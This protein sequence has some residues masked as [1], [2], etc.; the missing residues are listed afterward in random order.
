MASET[1]DAIPNAKLVILE[2]AGHFSWLEA[3]AAF[4][5]AIDDFTA[6]LH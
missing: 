1:R 3:P 5:K 6:S 2:R 4:T